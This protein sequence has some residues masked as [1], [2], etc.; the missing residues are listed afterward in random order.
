MSIAL[1]SHPDCLLHDIGQNHP[2]QP[3]RL[4][5]IHDELAK[6]DLNAILRKYDSP[7]AT[8]EQLLR[9]HDKNYIASIFSKSPKKGLIALDS[10][11][12][13][14]PYTAQAALRAAGSTILATDLVMSNEVNAAFCN[15][16]PPG[17]H[18]NKSRAMGFCFFNN[19]AVGAA[20]ALEHYKLK[21]I[22]IIDFDVHHGN[23]TEDIFRYDQR[24]FYCSS[25]ES[26]FYPYC[27][28][29]TKSKHIINVPLPAGTT[30]EVFRKKIQECWFNK[31]REF[32]PEMI[33]F[34]AGF[35]GYI[36]DEISD[37]LL[38][39][40]DYAWLT[41]EIKMIAD[42]VCQGRIVSTL[43]GGYYLNGLG[44]CVVAHLEALLNN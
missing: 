6:S 14:N 32:K 31:I 44:R 21:R 12:W 15:V 22:A 20:H 19:V 8:H 2:E 11:T 35:D 17:H 26:P 24:V 30:G 29:E 37:F 9:V 34:S 10:D 33:F 40:E 38:I 27:G 36:N 39:E 16:R 25:F 41:H 43:E 1:I 18:A 5:V 42:K 4:Q 23:G 3:H 7:I 13:M 28:T